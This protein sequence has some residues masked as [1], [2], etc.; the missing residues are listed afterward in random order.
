MCAPSITTRLLPIV[1]LVFFDLDKHLK[2]HVK[3]RRGPIKCFQVLDSVPL[4]DSSGYLRLL[5]P[6]S[7]MRLASS[8]GV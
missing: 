3:L 4:V 8:V 6:S 5:F 7:G 1:H 2:K